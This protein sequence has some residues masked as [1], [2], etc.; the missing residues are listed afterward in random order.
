MED[1]YLRL[2]H[3]C[4][5]ESLDPILRVCTERSNR[6]LIAST[7]IVVSNIVFIGLPE[8]SQVGDA[9]TERRPRPTSPQPHQHHFHRLRRPQYLSRSSAIVKHYRRPLRPIWHLFQTPQSP[10]SPAHL[11]SALRSS[12]HTANTRIGPQLTSTRHGTATH[13]H[14]L[15]APT[16]H[17]HRHNGGHDPPERHEH[18]NNTHTLLQ[19]PPWPES[20]NRRSDQEAE[21]TTHASN[22]RRAIVRRRQRRSQRRGLDNIQEI[23]ILL[24]TRESQPRR[25]VPRALQDPDHTRPR[26]RTQCPLHSNI[27]EYMARPTGS[28]DSELGVK[29]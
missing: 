18:V 22:R 24:P 5:L 3:C 16:A 28:R 21:R 2:I 23:I 6:T 7:R 14:A 9:L 19:P 10:P 17:T 4:S 27:R 1:A 26:T 11:S 12:P 15:S 25:T 20:P 13:H 8:C 29:Q